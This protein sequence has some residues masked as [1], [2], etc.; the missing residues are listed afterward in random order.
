MKRGW[1]ILI[2]ISAAIG[3]TGIALCITAIA[4]GVSIS[5]F[6]DDFFPYVQWFHREETVNLRDEGNA[7][8]TFQNTFQDVNAP[9]EVSVE[10]GAGRVSMEL[11]GTDSEYDYDLKTNAGSISIDGKTAGGGLSDDRRIDNGAGKD[12]TAECRAGAVEFIFQK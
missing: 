1:K 2:G 3:G 5:E 10:C 7:A 12:I 9:E 4:L 8:E 11:S 6:K